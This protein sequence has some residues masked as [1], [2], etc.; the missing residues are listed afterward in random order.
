MVKF[1]LDYI[2]KSKIKCNL[3]RKEEVLGGDQWRGHRGR[4]AKLYQLG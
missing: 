3:I 2:S 1:K 4:S